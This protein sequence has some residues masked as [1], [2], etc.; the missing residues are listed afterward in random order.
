MSPPEEALS[1]LHNLT[2]VTEYLAV[3]IGQADNT[4]L[5]GLSVDHTKFK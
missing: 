2:S 5:I 3:H 4:L 1:Q